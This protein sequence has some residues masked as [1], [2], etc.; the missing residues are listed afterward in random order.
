MGFKSLWLNFYQIISI[1][2]TILANSLKFN[3]IL[4]WHF[5]LNTSRPIPYDCGW[6]SE[7][8]DEIHCIFFC[9]KKSDV[10]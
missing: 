4:M 7:I 9:A 10:C 3:C 8:S 5:K 6:A 1:I 2:P